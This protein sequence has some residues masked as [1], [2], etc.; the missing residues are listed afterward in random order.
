M[1]LAELLVVAMERW[2]RAG[3]SLRAPREV[4]AGR[5]VAPLQS[6]LPRSVAPRSA[7]RPIEVPW[8]RQRTEMALPVDPILVQADLRDVDALEETFGN[9]AKRLEREIDPRGEMPPGF[10][11]YFE[12]RDAVFV[13]NAGAPG[14]F[15]QHPGRYGRR[16]TTR[17]LCA[18][19]GL[20]SVARRVVLAHVWSKL[21]YPE[22][23]PR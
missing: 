15:G 12:K 22:A 10:A 23:A 19:C 11:D 16:G 1:P 18:Q 2:I 4:S 14:T 20:V 13:D 21:V 6:A 5:W 8:R 7:Q 3:L 17:S 9:L